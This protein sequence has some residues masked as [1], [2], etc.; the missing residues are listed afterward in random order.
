M[1]GGARLPSRVSRAS[2]SPRDC[3]RSPEK[4]KEIT[5]VIDLQATIDCSQSPRPANPGRQNMEIWRL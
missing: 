2:R 4:R 3:P 5:P 1:Q